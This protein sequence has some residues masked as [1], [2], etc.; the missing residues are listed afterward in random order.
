MS[1]FS[2][3]TS[4]SAAWRA[5][6]ASSRFRQGVFFAKS[7]AR[8]SQVLFLQPGVREAHLDL[9]RSTVSEPLPEI[10]WLKTSIWW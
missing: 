4:L 9:V 6:P 5:D 10:L 2:I 1:R 7:N 3:H 8:A